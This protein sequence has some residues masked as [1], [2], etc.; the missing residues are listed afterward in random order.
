M[1]DKQSRQDVGIGQGDVEKGD[2]VK[3]RKAENIVVTVIKKENRK[4]GNKQKRRLSI[5]NHINE[6]KM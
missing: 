2:E 1:L 6:R 5:R 4:S 3:E